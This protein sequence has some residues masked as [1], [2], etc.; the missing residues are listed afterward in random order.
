MP[1]VALPR[2]RRNGSLA[3]DPI[4]PYELVR[5][6][7]AVQAEATVKELERKRTDWET[8]LFESRSDQHEVIPGHA[9]S[10]TSSSSQQSTGAAISSGS[11][12]SKGHKRSASIT[13]APNQLPPPAYTDLP[14]A[15][16]KQ[17]L[18]MNNRPQ[19]RRPSL[20]RGDS[21]LDLE[22]INED[23]VIEPGLENF[24]P[25]W[26]MAERPRKRSAVL[27]SVDENYLTPDIVSTQPVS[28]RRSSLLMQGASSQGGS[29]GR[30]ESRSGTEG[31]HGSRRQSALMAPRRDSRP[32]WSQSDEPSLR[33]RRR[34][35]LVDKMGDY[36]KPISADQE[37]DAGDSNVFDSRATTMR[38]SWRSSMGSSAGVATSSRRASML[39]KVEDYWVVKPPQVDKESSVEDIHTDE[40]EE[41]P[42]AK[43]HGSRKMSGLFSKLRL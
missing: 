20:K 13:L 29:S 14:P 42:A 31:E 43:T 6:L 2:K 21:A 15:P 26:T 3:E 17:S 41:D 25:E 27:R 39:K 35:S 8:E 12:P 22:T 4:D 19:S 37:S 9:S 38:N 34:S 18:P 36:W 7:S 23:A 11:R 28:R 16:R 5:R 30:R 24:V 40:D 1:P 10:R 32:D 33:T